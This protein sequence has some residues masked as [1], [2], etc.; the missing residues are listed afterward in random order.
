ML[1]FDGHLDLAY[2]ALFHRRDLTV[3]VYE[4]RERED[5]IPLGPSHP[6]SLRSRKRNESPAKGTASVALPEL[7][8]GQIG[9]FMSTIMART[10]VSNNQLDDGVRTQLAA[11][12]IGQSHLHYY[13][14]LQN[15]GHLKLITN[16]ETLIEVAKKWHN[17]TN[18]TP[19]GLVLS[20]ESADPILDPNQV[21][22]WF[23]QGLRSVGPMHFGA[24]TWG[25]GTGTRGGLYACTYPL[26]DA[27][28]E[29]T[30]AI[31]LTHASDL[32]FWQL[33]D[34]WKG[35]VHASHCMCRSL[36]P[37]QRHLSDDMIRA[38][39]DRDGV[40]GIVFAEFML[41]PEIDFDNPKTYPT[42]AKRTMSA[43]IDHIDHICQMAGNCNNVS[44]GSDL[45]GGFGRELGPTDFDT[46]EDLQKFLRKLKDRGYSTSDI[47]GI[48][49]GNLLNFFRNIWS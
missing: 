36:V 7:R 40:I 28:A 31:D 9:I 37:G 11:H 45:D 42:S 14:A 6:D 24:N 4:L 46:I 16:S 23:E 5:P 27:L 18:E 17:P 1:I 33:L 29:T 12:A 20:M 22:W 3:P 44:I 15:E 2:N 35:P 25:H 32:S 13:K 41:N 8:K 43:A 10:Q 49:H 48:A 19:F 39:I 47:Q 30:I 38:I 26:L 21:E 34:Y